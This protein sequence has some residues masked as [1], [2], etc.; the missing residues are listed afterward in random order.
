MRTQ[1]IF[2]SVAL[3]NGIFELITDALEHMCRDELEQF[4]TT[5]ALFNLSAEG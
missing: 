1:G 4:L 2:G 5:S 3:T